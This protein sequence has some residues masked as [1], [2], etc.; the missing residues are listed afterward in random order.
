MEPWGGRGGGRGREVEPWQQAEQRRLR[1][2]VEVEPWQ[3]AEQYRLSRALGRHH[4]WSAE[5]AV[6]AT[7]ACCG[8]THLAVK[9]PEQH[10]LVIA[11]AARLAH[12]LATKQAEE[13]RLAIVPASWRG[14]QQSRLTTASGARLGHHLAVKQ[15]EQHR[16]AMTPGI[17]RGAAS[18][19]VLPLRR[20]RPRSTAGS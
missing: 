2:A 13:H 8:W 12:H 7:G 19:R 16:L 11:S 3:Q 15:G 6:R 9:Q 5:L 10:R 18:C 1:R 17:R 4:L 20:S 14:H